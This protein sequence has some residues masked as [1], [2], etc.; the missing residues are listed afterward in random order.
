MNVVAFGAHP[1]DVDLYAGGFV[2]G[3]ARRGA[4]VILVDLS[5]GERGTRGTPE[6]RAREAAEAARILGANA[7][8]CLGF[9]DGALDA[10]DSAQTRAVV[11]ALRRHRP[12]LVLAPWEVDVHPDH[13]E[14]ARLIERAW[15]F[16][17]LPHHPASGDPVRPGPVLSYE[18]KIPFEPDLVVDVG[19]DRAAKQAAI[20]AFASQ[21]TRGPQ[22]PRSTEVSEP[23]F[24]EMLEARMRVR[25][26]AI[27]VAWGEGYKRR[28]PHPVRD[29]LQVLGGE[30]G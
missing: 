23:A 22:D 9:P 13:K 12:D 15:F 6:I 2:A 8:E 7:R 30:P 11:E 28:G 10:G 1:D 3:L 17:R 20:R 18:Q 16:A 25:G 5:A 26:A 4:R 27:G 14:A 21:F 29:P 24:H 19:L